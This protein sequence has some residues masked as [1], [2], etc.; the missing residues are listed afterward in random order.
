MTNLKTLFTIGSKRSGTSLL[1]RLLNLHKSIFVSHESDI[2]WILYQCRQGLPSRFECFPW[3]G[4]L[5]MEATI[6]SAESIW[7]LLSKESPSKKELITAFFDI[8][9]HLM[10]NGSA[11]Q[12]KMEKSGLLWVGDKKPAQQC[13]PKIRSFIAE[14]FPEARY[15][16]LVRHPGPVLA[17]MK[18]AVPKRKKVTEYWKLDEETVLERWLIHE[19]Q[20]LLAKKE[21]GSAVHTLRYEDLLATPIEQMEKCFNHLKLDLTTEIEDKIDAM[22]NFENLFK[23]I[24][25][26]AK[27][28]SSRLESIMHVYGYDFDGT[29]RDLDLP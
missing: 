14:L 6:D 21:L 19:E 20:V 1:V 13:D 3:D 8:Q 23:K 2:A 29:V 22:V 26:E 12:K 24:S 25:I 4:P 10:K 11:V 15:F 18:L 28:S 27:I 9:L 16:H 5:G 7:S 17:S